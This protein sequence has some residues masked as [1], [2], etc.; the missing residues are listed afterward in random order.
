M[1]LCPSFDQKVFG[2]R[3]DSQN[4]HLVDE[5]QR[6]EGRRLALPEQQRPEGVH[7]GRDLLAGVAPVDQDYVI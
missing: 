7:L 5:G 1:E 3:G 2:R 6:G 4:R